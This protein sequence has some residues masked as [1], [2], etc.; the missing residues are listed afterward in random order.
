MQWAAEDTDPKNI[1]IQLINDDLA[2][3]N[4]DLIGVYIKDYEMA[5]QARDEEVD[6]SNDGGGGGIGGGGRS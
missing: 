6:L 2:E 1:E 4:E 5:N 3:F